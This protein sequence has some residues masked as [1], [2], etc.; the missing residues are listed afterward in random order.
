MR[1]LLLAKA[2]SQPSKVQA[3]N[4]VLSVGYLFL[5]VGDEFDDRFFPFAFVARDV[6]G[7]GD[8]WKSDGDG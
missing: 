1:S 6:V 5:F 4:F 8:A 7:G 3:Y 2:L